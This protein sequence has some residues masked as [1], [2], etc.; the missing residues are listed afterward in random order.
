MP[1]ADFT[2]TAFSYLPLVAR[3]PSCPANS[4]YEYQGGTAY[5]YDLDNPVRPAYNHADKNI[6]L[7][8]YVPAADDRLELID[9]GSDDNKAPKLDTLFEPPRVP[10]LTALYQ[11]RD[12]VWATSPDPGYRGDP[13]A[14]PPVTALALETAPGEL[15]YVPESGYDIGGG[16]EVIILFADED[17]VA[18]RYAREDTVGGPHRDYVPGGPGYV[19]HVD[20]ICTDPNL[21]QLYRTLDDPD[22]PRY[23]Y[24][25]PEDRPYTYPLPNL[26]DDQPIGR[27]IGTETVVA[28]VDTG[29]FQ[30]PRSVR[31]FWQT[32]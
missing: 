30:D 28:V 31:E 19:V 29:V 13:I 12:W 18:L 7:R 4:P 3:S 17:T 26:A 5:Q 25:P 16:M 14:D 2:P 15:L 23:V 1:V 22:G 32:P 8:G 11:V 10:P 27:A 9:L 6:E 20:G 21:L 24:V